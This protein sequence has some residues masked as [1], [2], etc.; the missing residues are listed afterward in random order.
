[1]S[2]PKTFKLELTEA[3]S[4]TLL[5]CI[6][7]SVQLQIYLGYLDSCLAATL[8][9][10][11]VS[12]S[13]PEGYTDPTVMRAPPKPPTSGSTGFDFSDQEPS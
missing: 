2:K 4:I 10:G 13:L 11:Y 9:G 5:N 7:D 6:A 1:M 12:R 3:Q 8:L